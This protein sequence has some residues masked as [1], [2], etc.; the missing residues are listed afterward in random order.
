MIPATVA[1]SPSRA[2]AP[3][4][5]DAPV[6]PGHVL[7]ASGHEG[8]GP[9]FSDEVWN[10]RRFLPRS[11]RNRQI[12]FARVSDP[13]TA[14]L[15]REYLYSRLRR[16]NP[17]LERRGPM[18]LTGIFSAFNKARAVI[19]TLQEL[20]AH[21]L[22]DV[23]PHHLDA[24]LESWKA[25]SADEAAMRVTALKHLFAH[26][27][28][29]I[30]DRLLVNPW[31][32]RS[33]H[34]VAGKIRDVENSTDRI[35]EEVIGPL[36]K[37]AVFYVT[38]AGRDILA[39]RDEH[40]RLTAAAHQPHAGHGHSGF[41]RARIDAYIQQ[42]RD[43]GRGV[44]AVPARRARRSPHVPMVDGVLQAPNAA[45]VAKMTG[46]AVSA[47]VRR[48][49]ADAGA[50]IG[51]QTGGLSTEMTPWPDSGHPWCPGLGPSEL[52]VELTYLRTACW[53]VIAY[54]SGMRDAEVR[55]LGPDCA[56]TEPG[57]DGRLRYKLRG[58]VLKGRKLTGEEA[59]WVVLDLVH[60]AVAVLTQVNDDP[61]HL[62]AHTSLTCTDRILF[63]EVNK[64][65]NRFRDHLNQLFGSPDIPYIPDVVTTRAD[66]LQLLGPEP[67]EQQIQREPWRLNTL[68][69]RRTLAWHIAHQP[70]GTIAG[71][72]QYKHTELALFE[73]Y[74]GTSASGFAAEV[75]A[76][77]AIA[78]LDYVEDLYRDWNDGRRSG[79]GG[80]ARVNA[81]FD[82]IRRELGDLPGLVASP[83]RLRTMLQHLTKTL[84]PGVLN[85]CFY[86]HSTAVCG[87]RAQAAGR[88]LPLLTM[89]L[90]C[91]NARRSH[92]HLPRLTIAR[93]QAQQPLVA[94]GSLTGLQEAAL[95]THIAELDE[96]IAELAPGSEDLVRGD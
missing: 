73:G 81:E 14:R 53:I 9:L 74:A 2:P 60:Q 88:P 78:Q 76:E 75:A 58:K 83:G 45:L 7:A 4:P 94:P 90:T 10:F 20:G 36:L 87:H 6:L 66:D 19:A 31:P 3:V 65:L 85:D 82:R 47:E 70:F 15:L 44:P 17:A 59:E 54:L 89:C 61:T 28:F 96:A 93:A 8:P 79:G 67:A 18:K 77:R 40:I 23:T 32:G 11:T 41:A 72:R 84:H 24:A 25:I 51:Y 46:V 13:V 35:P 30:A 34:A 38:T 1:A 71:A 26:G 37:A 63:G 91:P 50:E 16:G 95:A 52:N 29:L 43:A 49:L 55:E 39:A 68:Q 21:R 56:F 86:Q 69:F 80:A 5:D 27:P 92:I 48:Y 22:S 64:R 33:A 42:L 62:F 57:P 12:T